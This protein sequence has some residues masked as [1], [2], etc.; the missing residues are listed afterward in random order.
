MLCV[1]ED[2]ASAM[3]EKGALATFAAHLCSSQGGLQH[4]AAVAVRSMAQ[5]DHDKCTAALKADAA[6]MLALNTAS[7]GEATPPHILQLV[8]EALAQLM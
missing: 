7:I 5:A 2:A 6:L 8:E 3:I 1:D 4:R